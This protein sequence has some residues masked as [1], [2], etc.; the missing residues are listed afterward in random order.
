MVGRFAEA[1]TANASA[2]R[3]A[4]F[5]FLAKMLPAM[6]T[7]PITTEVIRATCN[8]FSTDTSPFFIACAYTS[9]AIAALAEMV[10]PA[11]TAKIVAKAT[12]EMNPSRSVPPSS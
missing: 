4:T 10:S 8:S 3:N 2:T 6:A 1:A 9:C 5:W 11:T 7:T 12:A